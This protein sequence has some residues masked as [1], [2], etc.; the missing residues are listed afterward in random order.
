M[1]AQP[2]QQRRWRITTWRSL[3]QHM[4]NVQIHITLRRPSVVVAGI[5]VVVVALSLYHDLVT[6]QELFAVFDTLVLLGAV[7]VLAFLWRRRRV[8]P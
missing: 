5:A 7:W 1:A 6:R 2:P 3:D 4:R 8:Q